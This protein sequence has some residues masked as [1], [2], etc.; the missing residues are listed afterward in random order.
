MAQIPGAANM[1]KKDVIYLFKKS[2]IFSGRDF[3][4]MWENLELDMSIGRM[5]KIVGLFLWGLLTRQF[6]KKALGTMLKYMKLSGKIRKH[7][8]KF[9]EN[10]K[11]FDDWIEKADILWSHVEKMKFTLI[12]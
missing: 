4:S 11:D 9:P 1:T 6:S 3:T 10:L 8:E 2:F 12:Q 5:L 7:Y